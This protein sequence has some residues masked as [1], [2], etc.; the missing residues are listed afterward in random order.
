MAKQVTANAGQAAGRD[1]TNSPQINAGQIGIL[2]DGATGNVIIQN[3][4]VHLQL[5]HGEH[6]PAQK[7]K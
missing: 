7:R 2:G 5:Q 4:H 3:L 6:Q 1:I